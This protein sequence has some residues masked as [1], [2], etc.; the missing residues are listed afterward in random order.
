MLE[1]VRGEEK[2]SEFPAQRHRPRDYYGGPNDCWKP[3]AEEAPRHCCD[4]SC[5]VRSLLREGA[6]LK[7]LVADLTL[8]NGKTKQQLIRPVEQWHKRPQLAI[9][10]ATDLIA[11]SIVIEG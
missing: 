4:L 1:E 10:R 7:E 9:P 8:W 3:L 2:I 5:R 6:A 11:D